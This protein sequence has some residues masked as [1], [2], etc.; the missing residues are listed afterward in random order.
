V[1]KPRKF[2]YPNWLANSFI[3]LIGTGVF[4]FILV[5]RYPF[6][7]RPMALQ[8]RTGLTLLAPLALIAFFLVF[9]LKGFW[10]RLFSFTLIM[11]LFSLALS[12]LWASGSTEPQVISGL[13]PTTDAG[14][15]YYD[16]LRLLN[17]VKFFDFSSR[18]PIFPALLSFILF[19]TGKNLQA[20]NAVLVG[21]VGIA[22]YFSTRQARKIWNPL[23]AS[24]FLLF[25][26]FFIRRYTGKIMTENLGL[27]FGL[28]GFIFF[29]NGVMR[30][31]KM[32]LAISIL[33]LT[34]GLNV[35]AGPF[36]ILIGFFIAA[37]LLFR[38]GKK[39]DR[40][41]GLILI[42]VIFLGFFINYAIFQT[43]GSTSGLP[44]SNF[45]YS[46][47]GL[48]NN[49]GGWTKIFADHPEI[50]SLP[51]AEL[52]IRSY[53]LAF[54]SF[55]ANPFGIVIGT[56]KEF[57]VLFNFVN[58]NQSI[59]S[60]VSGEN[61]LTYHLI[62]VFIYFF[63]L[64]GLITII[65]KREQPF[66]YFLLFILIGFFLSI[67]FSPPGDSSNMRVFAVAIPFIVCLPVI[68]VEQVTKKISWL[69]NNKESKN[70]IRYPKSEL[71][72]TSLLMISSI[73][74]PII[75]LVFSH[76][77]NP[78]SIQCNPDQDLVYMDLR[79]GT[80]IKV[81]PES[82]FFLDWL[83]NFHH[84]RFTTNLHAMSVGT[85]I[86]EFESLPTPVLITSGIN[87]AD[88]QDLFLIIQD[89]SK[90]D[91]LGKYAICGKWSDAPA[92]AFYSPFFY[93]ENFSP[94]A[95]Q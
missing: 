46:L 75:I 15:Y 71:I 58:S 26:F 61:R 76:P 24:I 53:Q 16:A 31:D 65:K 86:E 17:G 79:P 95:I 48:V 73:I 32:I 68:G 82:E 19:I 88:N 69:V 12:G 5:N 42:L 18:R 85:I 20:T 49:G 83:P 74:A 63:A 11:G 67:P 55:K 38:Q 64:I 41:F 56:I 66:N 40:R 3:F 35:R 91:L 44:F 57:G 25:I 62:Q 89:K 39:W 21:I 92:V 2:S 1:I 81:L 72:V 80:S 8:A 30:K 23:S 29:I 87:L 37:N 50:A 90:F 45:S 59:Y 4:V 93:A 10:G 52:G 13:L 47:Y 54:E 70:G 14:E 84:G 51:D 34:L 60:V 77:F 33:L 22:C 43:I 94:L 36:F 7:L 6:P 27:A 78:E 9:R 28:L